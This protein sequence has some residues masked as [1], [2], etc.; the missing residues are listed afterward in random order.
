MEFSYDYLS[1]YFLKVNMALIEL[2]E[3]Y[4]KLYD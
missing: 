1:N 2:L 4:L 3:F